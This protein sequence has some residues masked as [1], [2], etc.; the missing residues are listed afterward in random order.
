[1]KKEIAHVGECTS[2]S[3]NYTGDLLVTSG[4]DSNIKLWNFKKAKLI[5]QLQLKGKGSHTC[6]LAF[7][8]FGDLLITCQS[9][10]KITM[11]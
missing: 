8:F 6:A 10:H 4:E 11:L 1:M 3:S 7:S 5:S 2:I 9:D